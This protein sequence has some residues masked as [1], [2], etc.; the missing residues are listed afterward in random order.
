MN[1]SGFHLILKRGGGGGG[2]VGFFWAFDGDISRRQQSTADTQTDRHKGQHSPQKTMKSWAIWAAPTETCGGPEIHATKA[3][4]LAA[5]NSPTN[6]KPS[7][8]TLLPHPQLFFSP[9]PPLAVAVVAVRASHGSRRSRPTAPTDPPLAGVAHRPRG[10][11]RALQCRSHHPH[12]RDLLRQGNPRRALL[13][14]SLL[15]P[16]LPPAADTWHGCTFSVLR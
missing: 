15:S 9:L 3:A 5:H 6:A 2:W 11:H 14:V 8:S 4:Y 16:Y 7:L 12:R 10:P 1:S 13:L